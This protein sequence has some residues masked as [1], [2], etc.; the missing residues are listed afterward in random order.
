LTTPFTAPLTRDLAELQHT[1]ENARA[2]IDSVQR[3]V[4]DNGDDIHQTVRSLRT[5]FEN[6]R[7]LSETLKE[8]PWNLIRTS[9]PPDRKVPQ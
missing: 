5:A 4:G 3:V 1:L 9:Q 2:L 7:L 8:R 6:V